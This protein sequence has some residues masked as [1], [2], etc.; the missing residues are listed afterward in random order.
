MTSA[1][2][3]VTTRAPREAEGYIRALDGLR[4]IAVLIVIWEHAG[5]G[6]LIKEFGNHGIGVYGVWLFFVLSGFL[7]TGILLRER[8]RL[9]AGRVTLRSALRTFYARRFLRIFPVY[10]L[11]LL[12]LA[13]V[14]LVPQ[15]RQ[16][17]VW[18]ATYLA[19][20][21]IAARA[22]FPVATG[23]L[24]S[25]AVEEQFY[26]I[27]PLLILIV[28]AGRLKWWLLGTA[29]LGVFSRFAIGLV[30][31]SSISV[32]T[33]T[34]SNLDSLAIGALLAWHR[35]D[36]ADQSRMR[37]NALRVG[38]AAALV[39]ILLNC[40]L[41]FVVQRGWRIF[42]LTEALSASLLGAWLIHGAL[43]NTEGLGTRI[44]ASAPLVYVGKIS[45][46]VYLYHYVLI[47]GMRQWPGLRDVADAIAPQDGTRFFLLTT[48]ITIAVAS[49]SWYSF[50][51]PLNNL[52]RHFPYH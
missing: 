4:C 51:R 42:N 28:P 15:F 17:L 13:V 44:L 45:Y 8:D 46:G 31:N 52:K 41:S 33:P 32:L 27:W 9:I 37:V 21:V 47:Y 48:V 2:A 16:D 14:G 6:P 11:L 25:L 22:R 40:Y 49:A 35:H 12:V 39:L 29:F 19:N 10:Y 18:F 7:I 23:H 26:L 43:A 3:A 30:T 1:A 24:W 38:L 36:H 50:E 34:V 5:S 20:W